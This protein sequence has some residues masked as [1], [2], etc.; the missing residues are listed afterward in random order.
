MSYVWHASVG[1]HE[2]AVNIL[3]EGIKANP[4]RS[5]IL[6]ALRYFYLNC[7]VIIHSFVLNFAYAE[8]LEMKKDQEGVFAVYDKFIELLRA[9]LEALESRIKSANSSFESTASNNTIPQNGSNAGVLTTVA[10]G[11]TEAGIHSNNSSFNTQ[12][13]DEK[14]PK[15]KELSERTTEYGLVWIMYMRAARRVASQ[16]AARSIFTR[17]RKDRWLPWEVYEAAGS[18]YSHGRVNLALTIC[19]MPALMEYH[20]SKKTDV[21]SRIF[22]KGFEV[23][24]DEV[25]LVLRHLTFLISVNDDQ[26]RLMPI[27]VQF[28]LTRDVIDARALFERVINSFSAEAARPLWERWARYE[29]Q[30]G[31]LETAQRLEKR[32]ADVYPNGWFQMI[33]TIAC[34]CLNIHFS[35]PPI[36]RFALRHTYLTTDAIASRDLGFSVARQTGNGAVVGGSGPLARTDTQQ[37]LLASSNYPAGST[38]HK[39]PASPDYRKRDDRSTGDYGLGHK[40]SRALSPPRERDRE[41]WDG[42]RRRAGSPGWD[43][44]RDRDVPPPRKIDRDREEEKGPVL[45]P[46]ISW[47]IGQLPAPAAFDGKVY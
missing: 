12:S 2:E 42:S 44:D 39:R 10:T 3:K 16:Q 6:S 17:G 9:D 20:V 14:P 36:K 8:E 31:D 46:V 29:Y 11:I 28:V 4:T 33:C 47:F 7:F 23:F 24:P 37:S 43:R 27:A 18:C 1:K 41:R 21:P 30:Y 45:P 13:S 38:S 22:D 19:L 5:V 26:S 15:S 34:P 25:Q 32:I 35:D 40:R